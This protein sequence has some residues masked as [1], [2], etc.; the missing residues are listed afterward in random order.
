MLKTLIAIVSVS[1]VIS[2]DVCCIHPPNMDLI[3]DGL[4]DLITL[5][6]IIIRRE[7]ELE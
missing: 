6:N 7:I 3:I 2:Y 1:L 4:S 5:R